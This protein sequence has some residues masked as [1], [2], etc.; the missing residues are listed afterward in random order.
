MAVPICSITN[1]LQK[2][3]YFSLHPCPIPF[4]E[5]PT[6]CGLAEQELWFDPPDP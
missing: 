5:R 2:Q 3:Q 1:S 6:Y 4:K